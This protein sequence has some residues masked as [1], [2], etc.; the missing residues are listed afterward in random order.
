VSRPSLAMRLCRSAIIAALYTALTVLFQAISFGAIQF[1]ISEA[2][3]LLP[4][5]LPEAVPGLAV[6]CFLSN[7]ITGAPWPDVVFGTLAT[8]LAAI[9]T[10]K[11]RKNLWLAALAPAV[12]NGVI[13]GLVLTYAYHIP[14]LFLNMLTVAVGEVVVCFVLGIPMIKGLQRLPGLY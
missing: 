6:G 14:L 4:F 5:L 12:F 10:S 1:R 11:L 13:I 8:L 7:L 9:T 3:C 2:L